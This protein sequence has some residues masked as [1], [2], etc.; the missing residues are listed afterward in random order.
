MGT[1]R[2][3]PKTHSAGLSEAA[4]TPLVSQG[5]G[6]GEVVDRAA[7]NPRVWEFCDFV[8]W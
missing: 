1:A 2:S 5:C 7:W 6:V 3:L 4:G 8:I